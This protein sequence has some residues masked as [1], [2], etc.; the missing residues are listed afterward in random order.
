VLLAES[1]DAEEAGRSDRLAA[2]DAAIHLTS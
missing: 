1:E 2:E